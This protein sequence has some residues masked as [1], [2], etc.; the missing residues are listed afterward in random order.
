MSS[1]WPSSISP[2]D[3]ASTRYA[4]A[5]PPRTRRR[6]P[7]LTELRRQRVYLRIGLARGWDRHPD[8][9]YLQITGVYG[10]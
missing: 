4:T 5:E 6:A 10:F 8:R 1:N 2:F 3:A 7:I 9:C